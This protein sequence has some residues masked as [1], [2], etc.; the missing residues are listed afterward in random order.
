[1]TAPLFTEPEWSFPALDRVLKAVEEIALGDLQLEVYPNQIEIIS[2]EQMLD[3]YSALGMP[4]MYHHWSF[5][6][7]FA[8][9]ENLY[10]TGHIGLAYEM[11]IN[12][13]PCISYLLEENS[14]TMQ[15]IVIAHAAFG[16]NHFFKNNYLFQQWTN[17][18][19]ILEYLSFAKGYVAACEERYGH[20]DVEAVLDSGHALMEQGVFRYRR[21]PRPSRARLME[22]QRRRAEH[23]EEDYSELWRTLPQGAEPPP[24]HP[25]A[26]DFD[27]NEIGGG[28][29]VPEE[30]LLYFLEKYSPSLKSWQREILR[31]VR[32]LA[33][34][35][36]PQRQTKV[37]NEG[38]ATFVHHTIMNKLY[39]KGLLTEGAMFEFI[40]N[41]TA[42][43]FQPEFDDPRYSGLNPY[44]LGFS[45]MADIK[46][47]SEEPT[48]ED[49]IWFPDFAGKGDWRSVLKDAWANYRDESF[50]EQFLS[51]KLM[52]DFRLFALADDAEAPV[53]TVSAIHN[54]T[55]YRR[56]RSTLAR[57]YDVGEADPNIQVTGANLK[58]NRKL[59]LEHRMHRG[60]PLNANLKAQVMPHIERLWG[61]EVALEEMPAD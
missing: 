24:P 60:V 16:H 55:G 28:P 6:K 49:R 57:Q 36:Y 29:K 58:G 43:V 56:V 4:L 35:F 23:A 50:I 9:E 46:R 26:W 18:E 52:R 30:N 54:D 12:S 39:D 53:L 33:Q 7:L 3:A 14:M 17:A 61:H 40:A 22:K 19:S 38:A 15:T 47:I 25:D 44:A 8:R 11:V 48:E 41:H 27:E 10:R 31:I 59:F 20:A 1:V 45:M 5:G 42:V 13:N 21:P 32:H 2:T 51:P 37:M 34:Y